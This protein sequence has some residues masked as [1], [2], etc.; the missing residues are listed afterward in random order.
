VASQAESEV[1]TKRRA[2]LRRLRI[3]IEESLLQIQEDDANT[4]AVE[5]SQQCW[6]DLTGR[7]SASESSPS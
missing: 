6:E 7:V 3:E 4:T 1:D 2:Q 5:L